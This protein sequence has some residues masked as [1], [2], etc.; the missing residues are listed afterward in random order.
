V[1]TAATTGVPLAL[2]HHIKH[3]RVLHERVLLISGLTTDA[4][5]VAPADRVKLIDM[6]S[7]VS[8]I[9][10]FFGFMET[11][12]IA[13]GL[14]LICTQAQFHDVDMENLT[15]YF[16]RET[17][18][19]AGTL[20]GMAFWRKSIFSAMHLNSH[21]HAAYYGVPPAQVVEIGLEVEI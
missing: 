18:I 15:Y 2:T 21:R 14:R 7:G 19:P 20:P 9:V 6:G 5:H 11:P 12:N 3:N 13:E 1:F 4:P 17:V 10:L 8:R 16:R